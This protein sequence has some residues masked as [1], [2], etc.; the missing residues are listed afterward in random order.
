MELFRDALDDLNSV[1]HPNI[2]QVYEYREDLQ[3][4][5]IL[6]EYAAGPKLF[7]WLEKETELS[8]NLVS[9]I[10]KQLLS[11]IVYLHMK[12]QVFGNIVPDMIR[13]ASVPDQNTETIKLKLIN[14]DFQYAVNQ[15]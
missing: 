1:E 10:I 2:A 5:Y 11:A 13:L 9:D 6:T 12:N 14:I 8:E 15:I 7:E 3:N 4:F